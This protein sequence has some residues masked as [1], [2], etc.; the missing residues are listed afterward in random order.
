MGDQRL[1]E[2]VIGRLTGARDELPMRS[3]HDHQ[4]AV[5]I[6]IRRQRQRDADRTRSRHSILGMPGFE[7]GMPIERTT[8][9][10]GFEIEPTLVQVN[11]GAEDLAYHVEEVAAAG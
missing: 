2:V 8:G 10:S 1:L 5:D 11:F 4:A 6:E 3:R 7:V 9:E